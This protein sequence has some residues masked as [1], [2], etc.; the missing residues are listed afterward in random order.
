MRA[1][2]G[3]R[4]RG[5]T[6]VELMA[7][8]AT[9]TLVLGVCAALIT[10]LLKL[11][12]TSRDHIADEIALARIARLFREDVR[13]ASKCDMTSTRQPARRITLSTGPFVVEYALS[14][15]GLTRTM[16]RDDEPL[17]Y[18]LLRL[19]P[20][21]SA[22]R[23]ERQSADGADM[24]GLVLTRQAKSKGGAISHEFRIEAAAGASGRFQTRGA[25]TP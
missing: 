23:F 8:F 10:M 11:S 21:A 13:L 20:T 3:R 12:G 7:A 22:M 16:Q 4:S 25:G 9:L 5:L 6:L 24:I 1:S 17:K 18:E 15:T 14:R 19:P 2:P